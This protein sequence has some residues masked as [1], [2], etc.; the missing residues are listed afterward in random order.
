MTSDK[1]DKP[2]IASALRTID[3]ETGAIAAL[4]ARIGADFEQACELILNCQGRVVVTGMGKSG[5]IGKKIAATL[6]STGTPA[7][8]VHPAEASHGDIGMI[9]AE[10]VVLALS[11][12]GTTEEI[13]SLLPVLKRKDIPLIS[14]TGEK[15]SELASAAT[16]HIDGKVEEE[17]AHWVWPQ[18]PAQPLH[19][20]LEMPWPWPCWKPGD[21]LAM[22]SL[23]LILAEIWAG[24]F[25]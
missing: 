22:I 9:T 8:Y 23:F 2:L 6:A 15:N 18:L 24:S 17:P 21:L 4:K 5:H 12:S 13:T 25:W 1:N 7:M 20:C 10:D 16:V 3:I 14:I 11:N 19:W